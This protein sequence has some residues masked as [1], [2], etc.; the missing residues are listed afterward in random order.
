MSQ[1]TEAS[2]ACRVCHS[3][4]HVICYPNDHAQ[5]ICP[6]CCAKA[7]HADGETGHYFVYERS[8]RRHE[9]RYCGIPRDCTDYQE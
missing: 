5:T 6:E 3:N 9:C 8:E 1:E 4:Q 2:P 7:E